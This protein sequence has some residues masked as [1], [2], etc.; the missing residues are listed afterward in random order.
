M[1]KF[2]SPGIFLALLVLFGGCSF[3]SKM[4]DRGRNPV[5]LAVM[6]FENMSNDVAGAEVCRQKVYEALVKQDYR[7]LEIEKTDAILRGLGVTDGGQ[8]KAVEMEKLALGLKTDIFVMGTVEEYFQ[9]ASLEV[10]PFGLCFKRHVKFNVVVKNVL[11]GK[12]LFVKGR[13]LVRKEP[14]NSGNDKKKRRKKG[15]TEEKEPTFL[16]NALGGM[17]QNAVADT[18]HSG[19]EAM[20]ERIGNELVNEMPY[21][22]EP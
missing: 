18:I 15:G 9:G 17:V 4:L 11:N 22:Y 20:A 1:N 7:V 10:V 13:E 21:F 16:E 14:L 8:L 6:P 19:T 12:I 2:K 5:L 3:K